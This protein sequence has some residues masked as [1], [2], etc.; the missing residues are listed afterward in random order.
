MRKLLNNLFVTQED[1]YVGRKGETLVLYKDEQQVAQFPVHIFENIICFNYTGMSGPAMQLCLESGVEI[2]FL[3]PQ[4]KLLGKVHGSNNGN[5]LLRREQYRIADDSR[6]LEFARLFLMGKLYNSARVL[7]R[8]ISDHR[9]LLTSDFLLARKMLAELKPSLEN[10]ATVQELMG[11]EGEAAKNYFGVFNEMIL[12]QKDNFTFKK[13]IRRPPT[14]P[15]NAMLSLSYGMLR[16]LVENALNTV[17]LDPYV[18]FLH[19]DRPGRTSLALDLMEELRPYMADR[20]VLSLINLKQINIK[21]FYTKEANIVLFNESGLK[22][23]LDL[24]N[25]RIASI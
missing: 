20:F 5:V 8:A 11:F 25:K 19:Q 17:G 23:Y 21:D 2:T 7:D 1:L 4:G 18:G 9:D 24:W 14:D 16:T 22:K 13:R 6:S 15:V 12:K 10:A 3:T